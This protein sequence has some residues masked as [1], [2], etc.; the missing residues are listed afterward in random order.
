MDADIMSALQR[1]IG[2]VPSALVAA[3]S[4]QVVERLR[5]VMNDSMATIRPDQE[6]AIALASF[7]QSHTINVESVSTLGPHL[8]VFSGIENGCRV[9]L[10]QHVSQ[11]NFLLFAAP[12]SAPIPR[13]TIGFQTV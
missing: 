7:G 4:Q 6:V 1:P 2:T 11:L 13:R 5:T 12:S 8:I 9:Q 10:V 3:T